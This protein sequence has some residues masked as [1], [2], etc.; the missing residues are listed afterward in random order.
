M[1]C[2][3]DSEDEISNGDESKTIELNTKEDKIV[4]FIKLICAQ[5]RRHSMKVLFEMQLLLLP[6]IPYIDGDP[7]FFR[8]LS[9]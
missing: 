3:G 2:R 6:R 4:N 1:C 9:Q 5:E 8:N 7:F